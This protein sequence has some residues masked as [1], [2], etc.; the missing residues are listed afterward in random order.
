[1]GS[2]TTNGQ[3]ILS[4]FEN[5]NTD[6]TINTMLH[7]EQ[8]D[9]LYVGGKFTHLGQMFQNGAAA[10]LS[11]GS[12]SITYPRING[13]INAAISDGS[14]GFFIGGAFTEVGGVT[15]TSFAHINSSGTVTNLAL[16]TTGGYINTLVLDGT[17]L[18]LG[19]SFSSIGG[20]SLRYLAAYDLSTESF[21]NWTPVLNSTV[22]AMAVSGST[23]Y[24]GGGFSTVDEEA[25]SN[26]AAYNT[27]TYELTT[28]APD[29]NSTVRAIATDGTEVFLAGHFNTINGVSTGTVA[30]VYASDG[31]TNTNWSFNQ[32]S[33]ITALLVDGGTLYV[34]GGFSSISGVNRRGLASF[35]I[36]NATINTWDPTVLGTVR[37]LAISGSTIYAAGGVTSVGGEP[38]KSVAAINT[39]T[40]A[41][42]AWNPG[43]AGSAYA[44]AVSGTDVFVGG[45][46][47]AIGG[48]ARTSLAAI[49]MTNGDILAWN[50]SI[51]KDGF[52]TKLLKEGSSIFIGGYFDEINGVSKPNLGL[53]TTTGTLSSWSPNPNNGVED[54]LIDGSNLYASGAFTTIGGISHSYIAAFNKST[55]NIDSGWNPAADGVVREMEF[56]NNTIYVGGS[57]SSIGGQTRN[58]LAEINISDG[59]ATAWAP[60]T[61]GDIYTLEIAESGLVYVGGWFTTVGS[62]SRSHIASI[63]PD[64]GIPTDWA[65]LSSARVS[66]MA[67]N[68]GVV[69]ARGTFSTTTSGTSTDVAVI[70]ETSGR[71]EEWIVDASL[72]YWSDIYV[73][74]YNVYLASS[75][76]YQSDGNVNG[77]VAY[78]RFPAAPLDISLSNN[79]ISENDSKNP[80]G[81]FTTSDDSGDTQTY[82][83]V[84]GER[85]EGNDLFEIVGTNLYA[86]DPL[87]YET[88]PVTSV[89]VRATDQHGYYFEKYF[90]I[91]ITNLIEKGTDILSFS[92]PEQT[93][94]AVINS[95]DHTVSINVAPGTDV[96]SLLAA[97]EVSSG[98]S[99]SPNTA[100]DFSSP[101]NFTV[102]SE[103][104]IDQVWEVSVT[105]KLGGNYLVGSGGDFSTLSE[106]FDSLESIGIAADVEL[107]IMD[108]HVE[109]GNFFENLTRYTG[110]DQYTTTITVADGATAASVQYY[111]LY[112]KGVQNLIL[113][114]KDVLSIKSV[115]TNYNLII[116]DDDATNT[117]ENIEV[118]NMVAHY[119]KRFV[120]AREVNFISIHDN[121][122]VLDDAS[123]PVISITNTC[124]NADVYNNSFLLT[125]IDRVTAISVRNTGVANVYNNAISAAGE[126]G[127]GLFIQPSGSAN[128]FHNTIFLNVSYA[129][130]KSYG[131]G[132]YGTGVMDIRNNIFQMEGE[133]EMQAFYIHASA[134]TNDLTFT[135]NNF[136][137]PFANSLQSYGLGN[138]NTEAAQWETFI[139]AYPGHTKHDVDFVDV[140]NGD[141]NLSGPSLAAGAL[142]GVLVGVPKD[143]AGTSRS[144]QGP[145]LGA[146]EYANIATDIMSFS[147]PEQAISSVIDYDN[148]TVE[149]VL[150]SDDPTTQVPTFTVNHGATVSPASG[151]SQDFSS[152]VTYT[153]TSETGATQDWAASS[154]LVNTEANILSFALESQTGPAVIDVANKTVTVEVEENAAA[155]LTATY[156]LTEGATWNYG[157]KSGAAYSYTSS[158][159]NLGLIAED[160]TSS[161]WTIQIL[162]PAI[163]GGT[164]TVGTG[165]DYET[166]KEAA[167]ELSWRGATSPVNLELLQTQT[168]AS[169]QTAVFAEPANGATFELSIYPASGVSDVTVGEFIDI[170]GF[171]SL[172]IDGKGELTLTTEY[173]STGYPIDIHGADHITIKNV[174]ALCSSGIVIANNSSNILVD[175]CLVKPIEVVS[176]QRRGIY[177]ASS[178]DHVT[179]RNNTFFYDAV[180]D[181]TYLTVAEVSG[182]SLEFYNNVIYANP[183]GAVSVIGI[184]A[185]IYQTALISHNTILIEGTGDGDEYL[186]G[187]YAYGSGDKGT[188]SNNIIAV[189][190]DAGIRSAIGMDWGGLGMTNLS[191]N[192]IY[193]P[194]NGHTRVPIEV[195][196]V[197]YDETDYETLG[198]TGMTFEAPVF[199]DLSTM[200]FSLSSFSLTSEAFRGTPLSVVST[201]IEGT[202]RSTHAPAKGAY[203]HA[204]TFTTLLA[205]DVAGQVGG[206]VISGNSIAIDVE[207]G[208]DVTMLQ[209]TITV[210]PGASVSPASGATVD[211]TDPVD[212]TVTAEA[213]NTEVY[214]VTVTVVNG[215][216][217]SVTPSNTLVNENAGPDAPVAVMLTQDPN[218]GDT[219]TYQL[220]SGPDDTD[221]NAFYLDG[222][223]LKAH[224]SFNHEFKDAYSIRFRSTDQDGLYVEGTST[225]TVADVT[226][227]PTDLSLDN[228]SI[229]E[230]NNVD[231]LI[232]AFSATD[233]DSGETYAFTLE[234][235]ATYPDNTSFDIVNGELRAAE[236]FDYESKNAYTIYVQVSDGTYTYA[237][238]LV[239]NIV[240]EPNE[241]LIWNG[242]SWENGTPGAG[243]DDVVI[244]GD[245]I[246]S[247]HGAID[248]KSIT[249]NPG[250]TYTVSPGDQLYVVTD[251][252]NNGSLVIESGADLMSFETGTFTGNDAI[253]KRNTRYADGRYSFV[254]TPVQQTASV[255]NTTIGSHVY[256][257]DESQAYDPGD[258]INRWVAMSGELVPGVGYTQAMQQEI[259]F[260]GIPNVS[261]V[262]VNGTY[263]GDYNDGVN[264]ETEGWVFV[265]NPYTTAIDVAD[266][267]SANTNLEG[268]VYIWD[269][270]GSDNGRGT[271]SDY[272]IAN[273]TVATNTTPAGG[274]TRYN[275]NLGS[276]QGFFVKLADDLDTEVAF[277]PDMRVTG[278]NGDGHFFRTASTPAYVRVNLTNES[279][280]FKQAIVGRIAG[281]SDNE[282]DRSFDAKVFSTQAADLIYTLKGEHALAI[283][284]MSYERESVEL[285]YHVAAA[286][287]YT[288]SLDLTNAQGETFYLWDKLTAKTVDLSMESYRFHSAA[289]QFAER[290][291][292]VSSASVLHLNA[293]PIQVYAHESTI[294]INLPKG[295]ERTFQLMSLDGQQLL[296]KV[297]TAS[298]KIETNLPA[299]VYIL[300]D[301]A[302]AHKIILK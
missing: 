3:N 268:A 256:A 150:N 174:T 244:A 136:Y 196:G 252:T 102:T 25:R 35:D 296:S 92:F 204:N 64:T 250:Y 145:S 221:N 93:T 181:G 157:P 39:S 278:S 97:V 52:I 49:D 168:T 27:T 61:D 140:A 26:I 219:H 76:F 135:A 234:D 37:D 185:G 271:N 163:A 63:D 169:N 225:I 124:T 226:E 98:G 156:T 107:Q 247:V 78:E 164:Y 210:Y 75:S 17:V 224:N 298:S 274:Q 29:V 238:E 110:S 186:T 180:V 28:W 191:D 230:N 287:M 72:P 32:S 170:N 281:I 272:I 45:E 263:T 293:Q 248:V 85:D 153:V 128:V 14:G 21:V 15:R 192:N 249:I 122:I 290:F 109:V 131:V 47:S 297:L 257:Y 176:G 54:L 161:L 148:H 175:S 11:T 195:A 20:E 232:G 143:I 255:T 94:P 126:H 118:K 212:F 113:D 120:E 87:D 12:V 133:G 182:D 141:L 152:T 69:Y 237:K 146:Y 218:T 178:N 160:G 7:D 149:V 266:F 264:E 270:N 246:T 261:A 56:G 4:Q 96:T 55:G 279:G 165:G 228:Q 189:T 260:E 83:L 285:A 231:A 19:G 38:Q 40:G 46:L 227:A 300:T 242:T 132:V 166:L 283:Q 239:I 282:L 10:N 84:S 36:T 236:T 71:I 188:C 134:N 8:N 177:I 147:V 6:G 151:V 74:D 159:A 99:Y 103:S 284:G 207:A 23:L 51:D 2:L 43:A 262:T 202:A 286:G 5:F 62:Q 95:T 88:T 79:T 9:I 16:N 222:N 267:L 265:S 258:G 291:E 137:L 294:Y 277:A 200:D 190:R 154:R 68:A 199:S 108:G 259:I 198:L 42:E 53:V 273:G 295:E 130:D 116:E 127:T 211:F 217:T 162:K 48:E 101:V 57:F 114:G 70:N 67:I 184:K 243:S 179:I 158:T 215:S 233:E 289:G 86:I 197:N 115:S 275:Q 125:N 80:V 81:E 245:Y 208:T 214:T 223:L 138:D 241:S 139:T 119:G 100:Q 24:V 276:A 77:F 30:S 59:L 34:G 171:D 121:D 183:T 280:L 22:N 205:F 251:I 65:P 288:L 123:S 193:L 111:S 82:K 144:T 58:D 155:N 112:L 201:D 60:D 13:K 299:G 142:R 31:T 254:G 235:Q 216:P 91:T 73:D 41:L 167:L 90:G 105:D 229:T 269:D 187:L 209:P 220:V 33:V 302:Q 206:E 104:G 106:A 292:L 213:G 301:G 44:V 173:F 50:P 172:T 18:Y 203:E 1:M 129:Y 89:R 253:I 194:D 240:D 117:A 66:S